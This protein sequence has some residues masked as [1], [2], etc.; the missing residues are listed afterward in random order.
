MTAKVEAKG[1]KFAIDSR[2]ENIGLVGLAVQTLCSDLGLNKVEAYRVQLCVVEAV[3]NVVKHAYNCQPGHE[4]T[5]TI[6]INP[7]RISFRIRDT[8]KALKLM[9]RKPLEFDPADRAGLPERGMG[10]HIIRQ[11]M[12]EVDYHTVDGTNILT[13]HK[14]LRDMSPA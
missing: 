6:S 3:T 11:V 10:L 4:V 13:M 7:D 8:G 1:I 9:S 14:Y 2:L 12:D 5:I